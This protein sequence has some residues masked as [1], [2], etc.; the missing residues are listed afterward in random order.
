LVF[1]NLGGIQSFIQVVYFDDQGIKRVDIN[2]RGH[3]SS[4][5]KGVFM[6]RL[7]M[8]TILV[9]ALLCLAPTAALSDLATYNQDFEELDAGQWDALGADGWLVFANV[10][11]PD[12]GWWYNYGAF[13][14]PN[15]EFGFSGILL[16]QGGPRQGDQQLNIY[17]DYNNGNHHDDTDAIIESLV[18]REQWIGAADVGTTMRF[19]FD[20]KRGNLEGGSIASAFIKTLAPAWGWATTNFIQTDMT[21]IDADWASYTVSIYI[22]PSL[23]GQLLQFGFVNWASNAE[24]SAIYYDNIGFGIAPLSVSLD[25]RPGGCPNPLDNRSQGDLPVALLGTAEFDVSL[26]DMA[27]LRLQG[28]APIRS[29][30]EDVAEPFAGDVC[31]CNENDPDGFIDLTLKFATQEIR[32][33]IGM[34]SGLH[35][36]TL[37]GA[38]LDGTAIEG[39]DCVIMVGR[40]APRGRPTVG[41]AS[42]SENSL[43]YNSDTIRTASPR[44]RTT[45]VEPRTRSAAASKPKYRRAR[46]ETE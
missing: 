6:M 11:G 30:H 4:K 13:P 25:V 19:K 3:L 32:D 22:D 8:G 46:T 12:W 34:S 21:S 44:D 39:Q 2:V 35:T 24:G 38:L 9:I 18:F 42:S 14:A 7:R 15:H 40:P 37:T 26:I 5:A 1:L 31:G 17:S 29:D 28:V 43:D 16:G 33:T 10:F 45:T 41:D 20:A 23:D 36:L 27:S